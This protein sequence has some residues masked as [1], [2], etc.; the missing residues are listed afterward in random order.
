MVI[1][2]RQ[3]LDIGRIWYLIGS[4]V[5]GKTVPVNQIRYFI[6]FLFNSLAE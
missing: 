2:I 6:I 4:S 5:T 1:F 3:G